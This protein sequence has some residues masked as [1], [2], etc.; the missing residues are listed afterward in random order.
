MLYE[1]YSII[2]YILSIEI[3]IKVIRFTYRRSIENWKLYSFVIRHN[4]D[5][6]R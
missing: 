2:N 4:I 5:K 1:N 3:W 6:K